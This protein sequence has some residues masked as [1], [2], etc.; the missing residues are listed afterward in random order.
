MTDK[1]SIE[2]IA[3]LTHS[4]QKSDRL[5]PNLEE[6]V[7]YYDWT[8]EIDFGKAVETTEIIKKIDIKLHETFSNHIRKYTEPPFKVIEQGYG[9]F[10]ITII[11]HYAKH[12]NIPRFRGEYDLNVNAIEG[13]KQ[14]R[15]L[16]EVD[17]NT[18]N[19][20]KNNNFDMEKINVKKEKKKKK[21]DR[22]R[23]KSSKKTEK[24]KKSPSPE[25]E[26]PSPKK[27][28]SKKIKHE[29]EEPKIKRTSSNLPS[30]TS[31]NVS[32]QS[33]KLKLKILKDSNGKFSPVVPKNHSRIL[34]A[35]RLFESE[36]EPESP[37]NNL[38]SPE[39]KETVETVDQVVEPVHEI[40]VIKEE[41]KGSPVKA[42][43]RNGQVNY[44]EVWEIM[45][46]YEKYSIINKMN[47]IVEKYELNQTK[48]TDEV[49][50]EALS[51]CIFADYELDLRIEKFK[52]AKK[53][54]IT[55][56]TMLEIDPMSFMKDAQLNVNFLRLR[57]N[58]IQ[59]ICNL[60]NISCM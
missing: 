9:S 44:N 3:N 51:V 39:L 30:P 18:L 17:D 52:G 26:K 8:F 60:F 40:P 54:L 15:L 41:C 22:V 16:L 23:E 6:K 49:L 19:I 45:D 1:T 28:K 20:L 14:V 13:S 55:K 58:E 34:D 4:A 27:K 21:K 59:T 31:S 32:S 42:V 33:S 12:L 35:K 50:F 48:K 47:D 5:V 46:K 10:A 2:I 7:Y 57:G 11:I 37:K 24:R 53:E 25:K 36:S 43:V 56:K 38:F 29:V